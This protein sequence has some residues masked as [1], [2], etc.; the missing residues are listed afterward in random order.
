MNYTGDLEKRLAAIFLNGRNNF[1]EGKDKRKLTLKEL[2]QKIKDDGEDVTDGYLSRIERGEKVPSIPLAKKICKALD[3]DPI[4]TK[5][6][7]RLII[8]CSVNKIVLPSGG[9]TT[10]SSSTGHITI[11][12]I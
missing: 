3:L 1:R 7:E 6:V 2:A 5:E 9:T 4:E 8:A 10:V 12:N 11:R